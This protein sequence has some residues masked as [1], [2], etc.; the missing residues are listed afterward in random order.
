MHGDTGSL[1]VADR[2]GERQ[3]ASKGEGV[4]EDVRILRE[5]E[6]EVVP[7]AGRGDS[8]GLGDTEGE[9]SRGGSRAS[10]FGRGAH[11]Q[12]VR[13]DIVREE[14]RDADVVGTRLQLPAE[15]EPRL[16]A[17]EIAVVVGGNGVLALAVQL[18]EGVQV[19]PYAIT[20]TSV[21]AF[22]SSLK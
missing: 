19:L 8:A 13:P 21:V 10:R 3:G 7:V 15:H 12:R 5:G 17:H 18:A 16:V 14:P 9:R 11:V 6:A 22:S 2:W 1:V 20:Q 4:D